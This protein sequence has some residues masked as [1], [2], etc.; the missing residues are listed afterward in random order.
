[1]ERKSLS[2]NVWVE[3]AGLFGVQIKV[4]RSKQKKLP[5]QIKLKS[6]CSIVRAYS[7]CLLSRSL[8]CSLQL[9][10]NYFLQKSQS[11]KKNNANRKPLGIV[12]SQRTLFLLKRTKRKKLSHRTA[13]F[14]RLLRWDCSFGH[15]SCEIYERC[16]N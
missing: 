8:S 3:A 16:F 15:V 7:N 6:T 13:I 14:L 1:M 12:V 11:D 9:K 10:I 4:K 5:F 2:L